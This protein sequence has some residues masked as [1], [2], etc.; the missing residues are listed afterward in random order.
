MLRMVSIATTKEGPAS[1]ENLERK[2]GSRGGR[3]TL[4][5]MEPAGISAASMSPLQLHSNARGHKTEVF[6]FPSSTAKKG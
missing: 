4:I 3:P 6:Y 1:Q 2:F 5:P